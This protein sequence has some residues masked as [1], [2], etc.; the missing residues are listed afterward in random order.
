MPEPHRSEPTVRLAPAAEDDWP[1]ILPRYA[2]AAWEA[3]TP[4]RRAA[5]TRDRVQEQLGQQV[6]TMR[7]PEG[8]PH[9]ATVAWDEAGQ[10]AGFVWV[11]E[12]FSGFTGQAFAWVMCIYVE[13]GWRGRGLGR[14]LMAAAEA[15]GRERGVG[16]ITLNVA[17]WNQ[18]ARGLYDALGYAADSVRM[19]KGLET[20]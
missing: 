10:R 16:T 3:L 19:S 7:G 15:W 4:T 5:T 14:R 13:A 17:A 1:W 2:E 6:A 18:P 12:S 8:R 11:I 20:P 9:A